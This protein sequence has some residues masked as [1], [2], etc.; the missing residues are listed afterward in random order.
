MVSRVRN[1][2]GLH[3]DF[4][5]FMAS[6]LCAIHCSILPILLSVGLLGGLSWMESPTVEFV[7]IGI[8]LTIALLALRKGYYHHH[9]TSAIYLVLLGFSFFIVGLQ[10]E[11]K[12]EIILTTL[13]GLTIA[14]AHVL[15]WHLSKKCSQCSSH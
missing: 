10:F 4:A 9:T 15:N 1:F 14:S 7:L 3:G 8:S 6:M 2:I 13:G 12:P 11:G 5:G